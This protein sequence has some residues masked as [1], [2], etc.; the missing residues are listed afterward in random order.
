MRR[1]SLISK[2]PRILR[3]RL[4]PLGPLLS[5]LIASVASKSTRRGQKEAICE[6]ENILRTPILT[7]DNPRPGLLSIFPGKAN[8][9]QRRILA[10]RPFLS[11]RER[12]SGR[13]ACDESLPDRRS[14]SRRIAA[15]GRTSLSTQ[16]GLERISVSGPTIG[17]TRALSLCLSSRSETI[18]SSLRRPR[19]S[20]NPELLGR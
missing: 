6:P 11:T 3:P 10:Y 7:L 18:G 13:C 15:N 9:G 8:Q 1:T 12:F 19:R 14:P 4:N 20:A 5:K 16:T 2:I 17:S